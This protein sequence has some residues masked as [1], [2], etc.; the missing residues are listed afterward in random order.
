MGRALLL[1]GPPGCGKTTLLRRVVARL[2]CSAHGFFTEE[3]RVRG[4][5]RGF[6]LVTLDGQEGILAH[7]ASRSPHRV[8]RYGVNLDVLEALALPA[9]G[10]VLRAEALAVVD[11]IGPM[12][13]LSH[14]FREAIARLLDSPRPLFGTIVARSTPFTDAVKARHSVTLVTVTPSEREA[15]VGDLLRK[16]EALTAPR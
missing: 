3:I 15:L 2:D 1:T 14:H 10:A 11:E 5:R 12:E 8:G 4:A 13:I 7:V 9:L 6:R 16:L